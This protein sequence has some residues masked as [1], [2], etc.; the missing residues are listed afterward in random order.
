ML[1]YWS[2]IL[3]LIVGLG[4]VAQVPGFLQAPFKWEAEK[5][6]DQIVVRVKIPANCYLYVDKTTIT[7]TGV[8][9]KPAKLLKAPKKVDHKDDFFGNTLVYPKVESVWTWQVNPKGYPYAVRVNTTGCRE[10]GKDAPGICFPPQK[11]LLIVKS[12]TDQSISPITPRTKPETTKTELPQSLATAVNK[13]KITD[14]QSGY[15]RANDFVSFLTG[16]NQVKQEDEFAGRSFLLTLFLVL[17]GGLSLNLTPCVLPMIPINLAIIGAG[18]RA[19]SKWHGFWRGSAYGLGIAAAYGV[20]GLMAVL[21]G[22]RFG[23]LNSSPYF[24]IAIGV[25]FLV[26]G[27]AMFDIFN[28]DFSRFSSGK[29]S[30]G[31]QKGRLIT[32]FIMGIVAALLAGACVAPV[33]IAV[34]IYAATLYSQGNVFSLLLPFLLGVGM[35]LPWPFAGAGMAVIPKPGK[36][37]VRVKQIF[38]VLIIIAAIAFSWTGIRLYKQQAASSDSAT[39][40]KAEIELASELEKALAANKKVLIDFHASWCAN[41]L[42]MDKE[43]FPDPKVKEALKDFVVIKYAAENFDDPRTSAVLDYFKVPGLPTFVIME[44]KKP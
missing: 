43:V 10:G 24:N 12:G 8:D 28:I 32:A 36:W 37:M 13:F 3:L 4:A 11:R 16:K 39:K 30:E 21:T 22:A 38:G 9:G 27:L 7:V 23:A 15:M 29:T 33:V 44:P 35:A 1:K 19:D 41:C 5:D 2:I 40:G 17:L 34:L 20:L 18:D 26:L 31:A 42:K 6:H 14:N 25:V